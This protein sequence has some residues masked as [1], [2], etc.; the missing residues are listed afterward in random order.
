MNISGH[1]IDLNTETSK[2]ARIR[3]LEDRNKALGGIND[4][5]Q[6]MIDSLKADIQ[7]AREILE[8]VHSR[9]WYDDLNTALD[10]LE[11]K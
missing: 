10:A 9:T 4:T 1:I 6:R 2:D 7:K 8:H 11:G 3:E 5:Q